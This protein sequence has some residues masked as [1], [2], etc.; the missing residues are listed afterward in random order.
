MVYLCGTD[1]ESDGGAATADLEEMVA[2][3]VPKGGDLTVCIQTGGTKSWQTR[4]ITDRKVER[5]TLS[6]KGLSKVDSVGSASMG[7]V[8][9]FADFLVYGFDNYPADRYGL[10]MWDHGSGASGGPT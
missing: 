4:G 6:G 3:G 7:D 5:W 2:A 8:S 9:T 10:I 1:L